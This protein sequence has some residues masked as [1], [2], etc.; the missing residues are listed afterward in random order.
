MSYRLI[1][2][3]AAHKEIAD[4]ARWYNRQQQGLAKKFQA[5]IK[6]KAGKL[7]TN[8]Y[9][10]Q[11]RYHDIRSAPLQRVPFMIH[12]LV[13]EARKAVIVIAVMH[14]HRDTDD[15]QQRR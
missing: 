5:H 11:V 7:R 14:T 6:E 4:A 15:W 3:A 13:D 2:R 9:L 1:D 10:F 12:Y 8:P